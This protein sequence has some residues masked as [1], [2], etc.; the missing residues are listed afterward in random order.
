MF[1]L[2]ASKSGLLPDFTLDLNHLIYLSLIFLII[3]FLSIGGCGRSLWIYDEK[4]GEKSVL[5][6][7]IHQVRIFWSELNVFL[8]FHQRSI[9]FFFAGFLC[10]SSKSSRIQSLNINK[11]TGNWKLKRKMFLS[12]NWWAGTLQAL[13]DFIP[14]FDLIIS[15]DQFLIWDQTDRIKRGTPYASTPQC[16]RPAFHLHLWFGF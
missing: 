12:V 10:R 8:Q 14:P 16:H 3:L 11:L 6:S 7:F 1:S 13:T 4:H 9:S 15:L 2:S 5:S